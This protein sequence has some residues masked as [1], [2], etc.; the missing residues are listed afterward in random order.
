MCFTSCSA[1]EELEMSESEVSGLPAVAG[2]PAVTVLPA[3]AALGD[4]GATT[5]SRRLVTTSSPNV[6]QSRSLSWSVCL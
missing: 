6:W 5:G 2:L 3:A 4:A 1:D